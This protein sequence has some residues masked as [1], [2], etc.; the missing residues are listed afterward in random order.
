MENLN[1]GTEESPQP[2]KTKPT[3][4]LPKLEFLIIIVFFFSFLIWA[5][6]KC[7]STREQYEELA[8]R[9]EKLDSVSDA[10]AAELDEVIQKPLKEPVEEAPPNEVLV[11]ER[12]T[13]LYVTLENLNMRDKPDIKGKLLTRL[14]LFDEV[15]FLNEV[16]DFKD[17]INIGNITT[18]EPWIMVKTQNG[19]VGW[20]Y[21]AGVHYYK[22]K[23][24]G[25]E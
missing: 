10:A 22:I 14:K 18:H 17:E 24:E 2:E 5:A 4:W 3:S 20:V 13:P 16:T 7:G 6:S 1:N 8:S 23:F 15:I 19:V 9:T 12:Y 21:G 25:T 11:K